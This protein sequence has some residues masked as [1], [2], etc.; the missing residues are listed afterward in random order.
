MN[1]F[2][3]FVKNNYFHILLCFIILIFIGL[4]YSSTEG[5]NIPF[6]HTNT[7]SITNDEVAHI[8]SS[9]QYDHDRKMVLNPEHPILI[10][11]LVGIP[12]NLMNIKPTEYNFKFLIGTYIDHQWD[13]GGELIFR[14]NPSR[15]QQIITTARLTVLTINTILL[16][17]AGLLAYRLFNKRIALIFL[18]LIVF[19]PNV[20]AHASLVTFDVPAMITTLL[21]MLCFYGLIKYNNYKWAAYT[22][23]ATGIAAVTKYSSVALIAFIFISYSVI[24]LFKI[25]K[26]SIYKS[27]KNLIIYS[28]M[29]FLVIIAIY[30]PF[31]YGI[32]SSQEHYQIFN[33]WPGHLNLFSKPLLN[34]LNSFSAPTKALGTWLDG[35]FITNLEVGVNRGDVILLGHANNTGFLLQYFPILFLTKNTIGELLLIFL[36]IWLFIKFSFK[37]NAKYLLDESLALIYSIIY[38]SLALYSKLKLGVRHLLPLEGTLSLFMAMIFSNN[39]SRKIYKIKLSYIFYILLAFSILSTLSAYPHYLSYY[40]EAAGGVYGSY[41]IAEDSNYDWSQDLITLKKWENNNPNKKLYF[42]L[43]SAYGSSIYYFGNDSNKYVT[44]YNNNLKKGSYIAVDTAQLTYD[45]ATRHISYK[46]FFK[47]KPIRP[48]PSIF[49]FEK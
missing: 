43:F 19:N 36:G 28:S 2:I 39:W 9:Y 38:F 12:L 17:I 8:A 23:L 27:I 48:A 20:I 1:K 45:E 47:N 18:S 44:W 41:N 40:N 22:G 25:K 15:S 49:I 35:V 3:N 31:T 30:L 37:K 5:L 13:Y 24:A 16:I 33:I 46:Q 32:T 6:V 29:V 34:F 26:L 11:V 10:K 21:A 14:N 42:D 4:A 7:E